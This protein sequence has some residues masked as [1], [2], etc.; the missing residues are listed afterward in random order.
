MTVNASGAARVKPR[1]RLTTKFV[2]EVRFEARRGDGTT[3]RCAA[4]YQD[5][6]GLYLQ[7]LPTGSKQWCQRIQLDGKR[8]DYGLGGYPA[9]SLAEARRQAMQNDAEAH[10]YRLRLRRAIRRGEPEPAPPEFELARQRVIA[11]RK[12]RPMPLADGAAGAGLTFGECWERTITERSPRWKDA[13]TALRSWRSTLAQHL[14]DV[15]GRPVAEVTVDM[16]RQALLPLS[17][18]TAQKTLRR[19]GTVLDTAKADGYVTTNVARDLG[20]TWR[21]LSSNGNGKAHRPALPWREVPA[22]YAKLRARGTDGAAAAVAFLVLTCVF[23]SKVI[24]ESGPK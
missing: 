18:P 8:R 22:F 14:S 21:G 2:E 5:G 10:D 12:G 1:S 13:R 24:T 20:A 19:C 9:V 17:L 6:L 11:R 23:R 3:R 16:L 4:H 15:A 7:V